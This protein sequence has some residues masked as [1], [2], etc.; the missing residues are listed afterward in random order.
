MGD[1]Q[2]ALDLQIIF[3]ALSNFNQTL[4]EP[5]SAAGVNWHP[6]VKSGRDDG[7]QS[8]SAFPQQYKRLQLRWAGAMAAPRIHFWHGEVRPVHP[9]FAFL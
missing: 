7:R 6:S 4:I 3:S 9:E 5:N 1:L 2:N 8:E